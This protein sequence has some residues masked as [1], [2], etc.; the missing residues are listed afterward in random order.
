MV[1]GRSRREYS[2]QADLQA[3]CSAR[4]TV[5]SGRIHLFPQ[6]GIWQSRLRLDHEEHPIRPILVRVSIALVKNTLNKGN[7][8]RKEFISSSM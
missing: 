7:L 8:E 5:E 3:V 6:R 2:T 4:T 1:T